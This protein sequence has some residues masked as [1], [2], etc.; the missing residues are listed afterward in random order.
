[1]SLLDIA[2]KANGKKLPLTAIFVAL[3]GYGALQAQVKHNTAD[4][5]KV[6]QTPIEIAEIKKDVGSIKGDILEIKLEQ[7]T[8]SEKYDKD[9]RENRKFQFDVLKALK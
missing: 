9:Q 7:R 2:K 6:A 5:E 4:L 8:F 3:V 1:M